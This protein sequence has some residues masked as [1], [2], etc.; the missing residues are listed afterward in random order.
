M[1]KL[2][3]DRSMKDIP[4]PTEDSYRKL[5]LFQTESFIQRVRWK[6]YFY[7][8]PDDAPPRKETYGF[9][10]SKTAPQ[11]KELINFEKDLTELVSAGIKFRPFR[12]SYQRELENNVREIKASTD[13][14]LAADK[15][16]NTYRVSGDCYNKLLLENVTK[17]YKQTT[18]NTVKEINDEAR[19]IAI[20]LGLGD[21]IEEY[22]DTCAFVTLKDH[23]ENFERDKKCRLIN[24]AKNQIGKISKQLLQKINKEV[25]EG[26]GL[27]QWQ[28]TK[29][30]LEWF[31][32]IPNKK[33]KRFIQMD[34][35]EFYPSINEELLDKALKFASSKLATPIPEETRKLI[36]HARK[37]LLFTHNP[38]GQ[39]KIPWTKK[40]G[41]FDVTMGAPDGAEICELVGLFLLNEV[42]ENIQDL[43]FG[44]Y[45]DDG[46]GYHRARTPGHRMEQIRKEITALFKNHGLKITIEPPNLTQVNFLDVTLDLER[47]TFKPYRKPNDQPLYV[48]KL[49]NHPP[50]VIK[51]I[52]KSINKRLS[53]ISSSAREF[54][55]AKGDYQKALKDSGYEHILEYEEPRPDHQTRQKKKSNRDDILWF[56]PPW[57]QAVKTNV[58]AEFL[59]LIKLHFPKNSPLR[60]I[61]NR[62]TVKVSYCTC[63]NIARTI[64]SHNNKVLRGKKNEEKAGC[65]CQRRNKDKCPI[66]DDCNQKNVI[67]HA[68]VAEGEEKKYIG[69]T[70]DFKKRWYGHVGSFRN[71]NSKSET[72]LASHVWDTGLNPDPKIEWS[73]LS[74]AEPYVKGS[75]MCDLCLT[76][77]LLISKTFN[78]TQYLNQRSE[79][80]LRCRHRR[81]FLLAPSERDNPP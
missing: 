13:Y 56:N 46:L 59:K 12:N 16:T 3:Y 18:H 47:E 51:A 24:P 10:T 48:H 8:N 4:I 9:K 14:L 37:S 69:S 49:S 34:I 5:L 40:N 71:E 63:K 19:T 54:D 78:D 39:T 50:S 79:M 43:T 68:R 80:A 35:C 30:A 33:Q 26:T 20:D 23:K 29:A 55:E 53:S 61:L 11:V 66:K 41:L 65:N 27:T 38:N 25:R 81:K 75:K 73:I 62:N 6:S 58:G 7:L 44:L 28:S 60:K 64:K 57:N 1:E 2:A 36:K 52:P 22:S 42:R 70:I 15:T 77:K 17:D 32:S 21:R 31:K 74:K 76:E 72:T 67:Y 45:R